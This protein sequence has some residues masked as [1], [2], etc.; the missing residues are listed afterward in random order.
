MTLHKIASRQRLR[1]RRNCCGKYVLISNTPRSNWVEPG[2]G[3][4]ASVL[5]Q[6]SKKGRSTEN[7]FLITLLKKATKMLHITAALTSSL[8][9]RKELFLYSKCDNTVSTSD[10]KAFRQNGRYRNGV[11]WNL[12]TCLHLKAPNI[13]HFLQQA[14]DPSFFLQK[15]KRHAS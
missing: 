6:H 2:R 11:I 14:S 12:A 7:S 13:F 8:S 15:R 5:S 1:D 9:S 3:A 10:C 4:M